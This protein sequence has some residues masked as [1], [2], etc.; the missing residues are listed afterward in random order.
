[1]RTPRADPSLF[2]EIE[3]VQGEL[4]D[5]ARRL[6]GDQVRNSLNESTVPSIANRVGNVVD[7]HWSTRQ[8]PTATQRT[9]IEI[10][11]R[12]LEV[13]ERDLSHLIEG[14]LRNLEEALA[15][16][17]APWTPGRRVGG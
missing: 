15:A 17:G 6:R 9:N 2:G 5:I 4:D 11:S 13:L 3:G 7:G 1:M 8:N 14:R 10:A 12:D 16:A